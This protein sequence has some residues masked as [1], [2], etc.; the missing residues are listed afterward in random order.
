VLELGLES[1][2]FVQDNTVASPL[3]VCASLLLVCA[4]LLLVCASFLLVCASLLLVC[5]SLLLV[6]VLPLVKRHISKNTSTHV[7]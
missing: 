6:D 2:E 5:A 7:A 3:L 4:S 1:I